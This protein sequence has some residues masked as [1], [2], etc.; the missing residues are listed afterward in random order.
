MLFN[1]YAFLVFLIITFIVYYL[2]PAFFKKN[3]LITLILASFFFYAYERPILLLLLIFSVLIN[4]CFSYS[5]YKVKEQHVKKI[6]LFGVI[7]NISMLAFFKYSPL[8][9]T[10]LLQDLS[11]KNGL[12][13]FLMTIPLPIGIS[14]YTFEGVSLLMDLYKGKAN[15]NLH[16]SSFGDHFKKTAFFI[17]FFPHLI[18]GPILKAREFYPQMENKYFKDIQWEI[19]VKQIILGFFLKM[20]VADNLNEITATMVYPFFMGFSSGNLVLLLFGYSMQIF[21]DFAGYSLI[22]IGIGLLFGY[23]LPDNFNFPYISAS[24]SEFWRRWHISLSTWLRDYLY[25]PL[26]GSKKGELRT[27][28]NLF[29]VMFLGGLWHGAAWSYAVWG[30]MHGLVLMLERFVL[31]DKLRNET[32]SVIGV[33]YVFVT[34]TLLWLMFKLTDFNHVLAYLGAI[35]SNTHVTFKLG[36][37]QI[38]IL[39]YSLPVVLYHIFYLLKNS[40]SYTNNYFKIDTAVYGC[41]LFLIIVNSGSQGAFIYFQF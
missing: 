15:L 17:S 40:P 30:S 19:A 23:K 24:F 25:I 27:Y 3:Q 39:F 31:K 28:I 9:A 13:H 18:A 33:I 14:F 12:A 20:V 35:F 10:S 4:S 29:I 37:D 5:V 1:S 22:A 21:A 36:L 41:M 8:I 34:V 2:P 16:T 26:G 32:R 38:S 6:L 11:G 7:F